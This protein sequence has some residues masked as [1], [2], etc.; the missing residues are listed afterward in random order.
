[1]SAE[2]HAREIRIAADKLNALIAAA[3]DEGFSVQFGIQSM[4]AGK[5]RVCGIRVE[6]PFDWDALCNDQPVQP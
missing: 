6:R 5:Q 3:C 4:G 1:M 2:E